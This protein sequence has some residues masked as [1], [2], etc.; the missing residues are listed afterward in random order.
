MF[1]IRV[2]ELRDDGISLSILMLM[3]DQVTAS[4]GPTAEGC[5]SINL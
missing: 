2:I 3:V 4:L 5:E 1:T